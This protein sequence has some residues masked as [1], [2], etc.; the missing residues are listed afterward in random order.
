MILCAL[1]VTLPLIA[2]LIRN[3]HQSSIYGALLGF[4]LILNDHFGTL[5]TRLLHLLAS[6]VFIVLSFS[7][8]LLI[9]GN[10]W[11][12]YPVI[13]LMAFLTGKSKGQGAELER[14]VLF[15]TFQLMNAALTPGLVN[16]AKELVMY[17]TVSFANYLICLCLVY[18]V[19][20]HAPNFHNSKRVQLKNAMAKKETQ[21][22]AFTLA[23]ASCLA[24]FIGNYFHLAKANW[25]AGTVLV[26][27]LPTKDQSYQRILHR[28]LGTC[29]GVALSLMVTYFGRD[30]IILVSFSA[31]LSF[32]APFG[33]IRNYWLGNVF[34]ASLMM[35]FMEL[36]ITNVSD[37]DM[38]SLRL[39]DIGVGCVI[40]TI[41]TLIAFA[42]A[43]K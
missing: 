23:I 10:A 37:I 43:R 18:L 32:L 19:M 29:I 38:A 8:G 14:L 39:I 16:Q 7:V 20:K 24:I 2:G 31:L 26:V 27:M 36:S 41:A 21:R 42:P 25:I 12:V 35:F 33:L 34:I 15:C 17:A 5:K 28:A 1:S 3:D 6:F 22:F 11:L 13:F 4:V 40:G 9:E 30:P